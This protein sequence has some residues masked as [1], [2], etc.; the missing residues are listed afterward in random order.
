MPAHA[1]LVR[2]NIADN[3]LLQPGYVRRWYPSTPE[4]WAQMASEHVYPWPGAQLLTLTPVFEPAAAET[5]F[6]QWTCTGTNASYSAVTGVFGSTGP[7][8]R[9]ASVT[10]SNC[11]I[12][13][14][15][16]PD[17]NQPAFVDFWFCETYDKAWLASLRFCR[18]WGLYLLYNGTMQVYTNGAAPGEADNWQFVKSFKALDGVTNKHLRLAIY[19]SGHQEL[20]LWAQGAEPLVLLDSEP[21]VT[22]VDGLTYRTICQAQPVTL[23]VSGGSFY[24]SYRYMR[25]EQA[26]KLAFPEARLPWAYSGACAATIGQGRNRS[27]YTSTVT[28]GL[29][30]PESVTAGAWAEVAPPFTEF[31]PG[32]QLASDDPLF[33]PELNWLEA[34]VDPTS[35]LNPGDP[36]TVPA[37]GR[38]TEVSVGAELRGR[39]EAK[40]T[41]SN[42]DGG[43]ST[44][45]PRLRMCSSITDQDTMQPLWRGYLQKTDWPQ[46]Q[47]G[48]SKLSFGGSDPLLRLE[49]PL[50]DSYIGDGKLHTLFVEKLFLR[51]GLAAGDYAIATDPQGLTLPEALGEEEPLFQARDGK[52]IKEMVEYIC[53][54]WSGWELYADGA[55]VIHYAP[56]DSTGAAVT[57]LVT[58]HTEAAGTLLCYELSLSRD[59]GNYYN[60]ITAIGQDCGGQAL[61]AYYYDAESVNDPTYANYLGMEKPL[62]LADSNLRTMAQVEAALGYMV[63][64]H[65]TPLEEASV[66]TEWSSVIDAG[67]IVSL[68]GYGEGDALYRWQVLSLQRIWE[69]DARL[70]LRLKKV[71]L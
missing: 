51:A 48:D 53:K 8:I 13:S 68:S 12:T 35:Q 40:L 71:G 18:N 28:P 61:V 11:A 20:I 31:R 9:Q 14:V 63:A 64:E 7:V 17:D 22:Q 70:Q 34:A 1:P 52:T 55:G 23:Q 5:A 4:L 29:Y 62:I 30:T 27:G 47:A 59:E 67:S 2:L 24:Y 44:L 21:L 57:T 66:T 38:L 54:V 46:D 60:V 56:I 43:V 45:W 33:S 36:W 3:R 65:A 6:D 26:G 37:G 39:R 42:I 58:A 16:T 69:P 49:I 10:A 50:S 19:P 15:F 32:V 25:F 41:L